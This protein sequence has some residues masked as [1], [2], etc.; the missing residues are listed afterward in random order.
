[1]ATEGPS[2]LDVVLIPRTGRASAV[3]IDLA[4][5]ALQGLVRAFTNVFVVVSTMQNIGKGSVKSSLDP[6]LEAKLYSLIACSL[7]WN[8]VIAVRVVRMGIE[9]SRLVSIA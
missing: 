8:I 7:S 5:F 6:S 3:I 9:V 1:M 2:K 4:L